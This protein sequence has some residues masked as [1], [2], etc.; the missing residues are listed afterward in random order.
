MRVKGF[1]FGEYGMPE[2]E[3]RVQYPCCLADDTVAYLPGEDYSSAGVRGRVDKSTVVAHIGTFC[4]NG[5]IVAEFY[6]PV[7]F[8]NI[9]Q[10]APVCDKVRKS[11]RVHICKIDGS[12]GF[13]GRP[14][15]AVGETEGELQPP[16]GGAA[17]FRQ[18]IVQT[19]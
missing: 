7:P 12:G 18:E 3:S 15:T 11:V 8:C 16:C 2:K 1:V 19:F 9:K 6:N 14:A 10:H 5:I 17:H 4:G 13:C